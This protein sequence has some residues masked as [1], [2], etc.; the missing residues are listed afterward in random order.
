MEPQRGW[1]GYLLVQYASLQLARS[2]LRKSADQ[3]VD[4]SCP[5]PSLARRGSTEQSWSTRER[6]VLFPNSSPHLF[7]VSASAS[8]PMPRS[9]SS[10]PARVELGWRQAAGELA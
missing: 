6:R 3:F 7:A 2:N 8:Y 5:G 9:R 10:P 1:Q 4:R